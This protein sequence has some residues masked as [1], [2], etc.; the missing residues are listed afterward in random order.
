MTS[1]IQD[2]FPDGNPMAK[3]GDGARPLPTTTP[4]PQSLRAGSPGLPLLGGLHP[5]PAHPSLRPAPFRG[6]LSAELL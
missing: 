1:H 6:G 4:P 2:P 3:L 5:A